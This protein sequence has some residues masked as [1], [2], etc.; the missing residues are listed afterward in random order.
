[1]IS[2]QNGDEDC[3]LVLPNPGNFKIVWKLVAV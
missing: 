1:M 2:D 3:A